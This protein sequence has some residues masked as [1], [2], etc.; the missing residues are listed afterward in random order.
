S[1]YYRSC[2]FIRGI[3]KGTWNYW[4]QEAMVR[5][6]FSYSYL[7]LKYYLLHKSSF[8]VEINNPDEWIEKIESK[9][10]EELELINKIIL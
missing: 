3:I 9:L 2:A 1:I 10:N 4:I 6:G 7:Q 8:P 5:S